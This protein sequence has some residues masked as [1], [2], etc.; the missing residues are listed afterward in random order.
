M[1][2]ADLAA[3]RPA[4]P[5]T[6]VFV[7]LAISFRAVMRRLDKRAADATAIRELDAMPDYMLRDMGLDRLDIRRR[8]RG[9]RDDD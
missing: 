6:G 9:L 3:A 1:T 2:F 4:R 8:V 5:V 7:R